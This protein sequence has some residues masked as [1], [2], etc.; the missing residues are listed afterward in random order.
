MTKTKPRRR[1]PGEGSAFEYKLANGTQRWG[2]KFVLTLDDGTKKTVLRR[3]DENNQPWLTKKAA[4]AALRDALTKADKGE[5]IDPSKQPTGDYLDTWAAGLRL[6]ASTVASYRRNLRLHVKP[7][8]GGIALASL[9]SAKLNELYRMLEE[10]GHRN[11]KGELD[12]KPL[13]ARTVRYVH[14]ILSAALQA[15]VDAEPAMLSRNP[16]DKAKPPTAKEAKSPEMR[17]WTAAQLAAFL[18]WTRE[19]S[20]LHAAWWVL[21]MT[22]MRRGELLALRWRDLDLAAGTVS[23]RRSVGVILVK[24]QKSYLKEG[25]TKTAKPRVVD[26]DAATVDVFKDWWRERAALSAELVRDDALIF[27]TEE[28]EWRHPHGFSSRFKKTLAR[29]RRDQAKAGAVPVP[30]VRLH[31]LRHTHATLLLMKG[32]PVKVVSE[33]LGHSSAIITLTIY[34]HV[35]PGNQR[36]AAYQFAAL[37]ADAGNLDRPAGGIAQVSEPVPGTP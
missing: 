33:R 36:D 5:W 21:A 27:G 19:H 4:Q 6:S 20:Y 28:G 15:A 2:I 9:T 14:T 1:S 24:G 26:L 17:P 30:E 34:A 7:Y 25:D 35:L 8:I 18:A 12:G 22:G 31:D 37:I 13:S 32:I 10:K 3:R 16:A 11:N 23:I 29:F